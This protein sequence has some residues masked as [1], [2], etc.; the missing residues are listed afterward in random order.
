M[1]CDSRSRRL[2]RDEPEPI[3]GH[4]PQ[5]LAL[6][7]VMRPSLRAA[8]YNALGTLFALHV[9]F[10]GKNCRPGAECRVAT[11]VFVLDFRH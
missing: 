11:A 3:G 4:R 10:E 8:N 7:V 6:R 5:P 1:C 9:A 2:Y